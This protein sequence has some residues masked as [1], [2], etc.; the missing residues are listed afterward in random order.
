MNLLEDLTNLLLKFKFVSIHI[1]HKILV[2]IK[3]HTN[4]LQY[5][6]FECF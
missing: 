4:Y 5:N 1:I 2:L 3:N 6:I